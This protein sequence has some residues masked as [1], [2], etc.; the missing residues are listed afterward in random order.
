[1]LWSLL[2]CC[3]QPNAYNRTSGAPRE[4]VHSTLFVAFSALRRESLAL[5]SAAPPTVKGVYFP[6]SPIYSG[7]TLQSVSL[8]FLK[9]SI[10]ANVCLA[11]GMDAEP[12]RKAAYN[13]TLVERRADAFRSS[14]KK[15]TPYRF[16]NVIT[17]DLS[18][19][20]VSASR[21]AEMCDV[22]FV[23]SIFLYLFDYLFIHLFV[24]KDDFNNP[25]KCVRYLTVV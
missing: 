21:T 11:L 16:W 3:R 22:G 2:T 8:D 23:V 4:V 12:P 10:T 20:Q 7:P 5:Q 19:R 13:A 6:A 1:V 14:R 25:W 15:Q 9:V 18:Q 17:W 24:F